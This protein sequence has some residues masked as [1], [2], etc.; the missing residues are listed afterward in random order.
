[1]LFKHLYIESGKLIKLNGVET[2]KST[3]VDQILLT[4]NQPG[5]NT[6]DFGSFLRTYSILDTRAHI[7]LS[8]TLII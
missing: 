3:F 8:K 2:D 6:E 5:S 7:G 1:M 4:E